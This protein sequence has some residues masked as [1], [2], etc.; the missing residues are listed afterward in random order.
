[1]YKISISIYLVAGGL[2]NS[3][4]E[5]LSS[6]DDDF[7]EVLIIGLLR[8][9]GSDHHGDPNYRGGKTFLFCCLW[10]KFGSQT[11]HQLC[12]PGS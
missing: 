4:P 6:V 1:M 2:P 3:F 8:F 12:I 11:H 5:T 7:Y 10:Y 9:I